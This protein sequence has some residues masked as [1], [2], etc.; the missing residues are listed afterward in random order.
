MEENSVSQSGLTRVLFLDTRQ[1]L[2]TSISQVSSHAL[3]KT[4]TSI[5][6]APDSEGDY[7]L[8][9]LLKKK[10]RYLRLASVEGILTRSEFLSSWRSSR[11]LLGSLRRFLENLW[12]CS[13]SWDSFPAS[14][15][16]LICRN[17]C[18]S[19]NF[20]ETFETTSEVLRSSVGI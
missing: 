12:R 17:K 9:G 18:G 19:S 20:Y 1:K 14:S 6:V 11:Q 5:I 16:L 10:A 8:M 7:T 13:Y 3:E 4:R 15:Y 2:G